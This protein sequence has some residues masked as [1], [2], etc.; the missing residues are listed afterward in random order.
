MFHCIWEKLYQAFCSTMFW[1][2]FNNPNSADFT[3]YILKRFFAVKLEITMMDCDLLYTMW[4]LTS[5]AIFS[6]RLNGIQY[7]IL[8]KIFSF[9]TRKQHKK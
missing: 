8:S 3:R 9:V 5:V 1:F 6:Q 4:N 7:G 2:C